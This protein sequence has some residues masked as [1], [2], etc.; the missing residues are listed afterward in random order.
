M[1]KS[2]NQINTHWDNAIFSVHM[3]SNNHNIRCNRLLCGFGLQLVVTICADVDL[4]RGSYRCFVVGQVRYGYHKYSGTDHDR[5]RERQETNLT[6]LHYPYTWSTTNMLLPIVI[7]RK[8]S[9]FL[10]FWTLIDG[11]HL[12]RL[13]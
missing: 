13:R 7:D 9:F 11:R 2:E 6:V 3:R 8:I 12:C 10:W 1:Y 4:I 5:R